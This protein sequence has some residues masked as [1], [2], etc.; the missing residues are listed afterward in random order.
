MPIN[1]QQYT[2]EQLTLQADVAK[3]DERAALV[4]SLKVH[5]FRRENKLIRNA[6]VAILEAG[7]PNRGLKAPGQ[8][9]A[10]LVQQDGM[11][12]QL[13][14]HTGSRQTNPGVGGVTII[15]PDGGIERHG[16]TTVPVTQDM[17]DNVMANADGDGELGETA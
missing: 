16:Q 4:A 17:V 8:V 3:D 10:A 15:N 7:D 2:L 14:R 9:G 5:G 13:I 11:G 12:R 6:L 1:P